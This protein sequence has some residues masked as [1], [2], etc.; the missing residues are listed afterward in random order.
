MPDS[1]AA[2]VPD[3]PGRASPPGPVR[4]SPLQRWRRLAWGAVAVVA[5]ALAALGSRQGS[6]AAPLVRAGANV[7]ASSLPG[8]PAPGFTLTDQRGRPQSLAAFR[9]RVVVLSFIDSRCT[10]ICP[11][12]AQMLRTAMAEIGPQ[13]AHVQLLAV[14]VNRFA[15]SVADVRAWTDQH[16][17]AG[18]WLFLTGPVP[19]L[20]GVWAAYHVAVE[21]TNAGNIQHTAALYVIGRHGRERWLMTSE[22]S[23]GSIDTEAHALA[24]QVM[25]VLR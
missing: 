4:P 15:N 25:G 13:A 14:N 12:T 5:L 6:S 23:A 18:R 16:G 10:T 1:P 21:G 17:M 3:S 7:F 24:S 8:T 22:A 11:L 9:G 2:P 20:R 19:T